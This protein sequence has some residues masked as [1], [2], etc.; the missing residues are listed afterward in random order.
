MTIYPSDYERKRI[1][2]QV[3]HAEIALSPCA[4]LLQPYVA[5][6]YESLQVVFGRPSRS[7]SRSLSRTPGWV[8]S[9][10]IDVTPRAESIGERISTRRGLYIVHP[11]TRILKWRLP[12]RAQA[13]AQARCF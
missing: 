13:R 4:T 12:S 10:G 2:R 7:M 3:E 9:T 8:V 11:E 6:Y 5:H 1:R